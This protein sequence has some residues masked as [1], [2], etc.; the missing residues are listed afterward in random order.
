MEEGMALIATL[1]SD[2]AR[3]EGSAYVGRADLDLVEPLELGQI[4]IIEDTSTGERLLGRIADVLGADTE[5]VYR[6]ALGP[7]FP[8]DDPTEDAA[9]TSRYSLQDIEQMLEEA[10]DHDIRIP[11]P[12][13]PEDDPEPE[14]G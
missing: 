2:R 14:D 13:E 6:I 12:R 7:V 3:R 9:S 5:T 8:V 4:V 10:R 1:L 11:Q